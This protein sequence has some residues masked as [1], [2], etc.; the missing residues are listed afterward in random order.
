MINYQK[1]FDLLVAELPKYINGPIKISYHRCH[2]GGIT[3]DVCVKR[4]MNPNLAWPV[5]VLGRYITEFKPE[6]L[7]NMIHKDLTK[8]YIRFFNWEPIFLNY[9]GTKTFAEY[10]TSGWII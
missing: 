5:G 1:A 7:L 8:K 2:D 9:E 4:S 10:C 3:I 6:C